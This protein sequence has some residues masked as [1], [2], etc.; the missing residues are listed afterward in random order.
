MT[1]FPYYPRSNGFI[2]SQVKSVKAALL[3]AKTSHRDL[4]LRTTPINHK[5]P[6]PA[7][8]LLGRAIQDNLPRKIPRDTLNKVVAPRLEKRQ[9]LQKFCH[10]RSA[11]QLPA[12]TSGH[13][14]SIDTEMETSRSKRKARRS[15]PVICCVNPNWKRAEAH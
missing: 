5:L 3:K 12:L 14:G 10:D 6:T 7:E 11:G 2:E 13:P 15:R 9:E 8:L 4:C 1:S